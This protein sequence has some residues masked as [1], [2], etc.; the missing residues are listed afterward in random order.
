MAH[1]WWRPLR[2]HF[3][4]DAPRMAVRTRLP[5]PWRVGVGAL[6]VAIIGGM[7]WWGFDFGQIFG[8][9]NRQE[10]ES[11]LASLEA[12]AAKLRQ[13]ATE[14]RGRATQ[15][16]SD[17]AMTQATLATMSKQSLEQQNEATQLKEEVAFLRTLVADANRNP[18]V[19]IQRVS[20]ERESAD[21]WH[22]S[23]LV[24]RGGN[25]RED[26]QGHLALSVALGGGEPRTAALTLPDDQPDQAP[27]LNLRFKY[28][29]RVEGSFRVPAGTT[30]RS[31]TVR[32]FES[33]H[34]TPRATRNETIS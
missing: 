33:G 2:Q 10:V 34:A 18:G 4:I 7:W 23:L 27:A 28:Y 21:R 12:E 30:P 20:V 15:A 22:Y 14:L 25:P 19:S 5:W 16:E 29:Q 32:A 13:E 3:G 11:K 8:G 9:F 24:V 26:F 1:A 17:L 6:V 31:L